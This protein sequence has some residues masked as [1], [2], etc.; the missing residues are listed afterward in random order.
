MFCD[1]LFSERLREDWPHGATIARIRFL[2]PK[3]LTCPPLNASKR[4]WLYGSTVVKP[5]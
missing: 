4:V 2:E 5:G 1:M 3:I